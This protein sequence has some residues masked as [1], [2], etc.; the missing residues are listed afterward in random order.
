MISFSSS[1]SQNFDS[2]ASSGT[3]LSWSNDVTLAGWFLFRQSAN[4]PEAITGYALA[5]AA[6]IRAA[7]T[8]MAQPVPAT[9][10]W[11]A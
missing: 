11:A 1:Y 5:R 7:S 3:S 9:V 6:S 8:V 2:L 4:G 10:P